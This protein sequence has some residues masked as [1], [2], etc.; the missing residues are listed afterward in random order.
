MNIGTTLAVYANIC[1]NVGQ[2]FI[3]PGSEAQWN[4]VSDVTDTGILAKQL[5]WAATTQEA[6]NNA[7]NIVNGDVFRWKWLWERFARYFDIEVEG[8]NG[9]VR[10]LEEQMR[11]D[12]VIWEDIVKRYG[13]Q[14]NNLYQLTSPW[15]R[16]LD[17]GRPIEV[18]TDMANSR[19]LGFKEYQNTEESFI[20]L[21]EELRKEKIIP[22]NS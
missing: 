5:I 21:F 7:F 14:Q 15:H 20:K 18:M 17:L 13:F 8:F 10:P 2:K 22:F 1:K 6:K 16:D 11:N 19:K 3:W 12:S 4:G 9:T